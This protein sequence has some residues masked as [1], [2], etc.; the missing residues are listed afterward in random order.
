[1]VSSVLWYADCDERITI[2][3]HLGLRSAGGD[4]LQVNR[5]SGTWWERSQELL[6]R[7]LSVSPI[8]DSDPRGPGTVVTPCKHSASA[9]AVDQHGVVLV[10]LVQDRRNAAVAKRFFTWCFLDIACSSPLPT[11][12]NLR[13]PTLRLSRRLIPKCRRHRCARIGRA[14]WT[15]YAAPWLIRT[16]P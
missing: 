6:T 10:V 1:M 8:P 16:H 7:N 15:T 9:S 5:G 2:A 14:V 3:R 11:K 13:N 12:Y 4:R